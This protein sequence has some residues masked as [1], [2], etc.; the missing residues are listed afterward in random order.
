M[1][2]IIDLICSKLN[3]GSIEISSDIV[4][5]I[6][7]EIISDKLYNKYFVVGIWKKKVIAKIS[8]YGGDLNSSGV[9]Q[10]DDD[11]IFKITDELLCKSFNDLQSNSSSVCRNCSVETSKTRSGSYCPYLSGLVDYTNIDKLDKFAAS[12]AAVEDDNCFQTPPPKIMQ[13]PPTPPKKR[14]RLDL[15]LSIE[16]PNFYN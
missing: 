11:L 8:S 5:N 4:L 6:I 16:P 13:D 3:E 9:K 1:E 10:I 2:N 12:I 15:T 7:K 14:R